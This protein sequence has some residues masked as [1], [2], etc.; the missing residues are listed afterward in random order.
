MQPTG[1]KVMVRPRAGEEKTE[2]G[3]SLPETTRDKLTVE[4]EV[5]AV[6]PGRRL[7]NGGYV[8]IAVEPGQVVVLRTKE[9]L[10]VRN[11]EETLLLVDEKDLL[12]VVE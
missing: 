12:G 8:P 10:E 2:S 5:V 6:G 9:Q 4:A 11:G 3:I 1:T 7:P